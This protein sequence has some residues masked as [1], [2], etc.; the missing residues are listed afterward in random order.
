MVSTAAMSQIVRVRG[1]PWLNSILCTVLIQRYILV[2]PALKEYPR[3]IYF[4]FD[5]FI[6]KSTPIRDKTMDDKFMYIPNSFIQN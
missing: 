4:Y 1:M 6:S 5:L 2:R 3:L